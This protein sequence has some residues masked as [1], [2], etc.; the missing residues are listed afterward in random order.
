MEGCPYYGGIAFGRKGRSFSASAN[1]NSTSGNA[2]VPPPSIRNTYF[3]PG[4]PDSVSA[5]NQFYRSPNDSTPPGTYPCLIQEP[6]S[7]HA[8]LTLDYHATPGQKAE[9]GRTTLFI[10]QR[11][12][13]LSSL[14]DSLLTNLF[15]NTYRVQSPGRHPVSLWNKADPG[16]R[17]DGDTGR[18]KR[19][20]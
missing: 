12:G 7:Q 4:Q 20:P 8:S 17:G 5:V 3:Q 6:L 18:G 19:K 11:D 13:A 2:R 14:A 16:N 9:T 1:I 15:S 10:R